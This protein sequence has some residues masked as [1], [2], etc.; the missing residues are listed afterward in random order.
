MA[1]SQAD[2]KQTMNVSIIKNILKSI[3]SRSKPAADELTTETIPGADRADWLLD[4]YSW[5]PDWKEILD[6]NWDDWNMLVKKTKDGPKVLI[7]TS[8]GG[9]SALTPFESLLGV[10]L[11]LRGADVHYILCDKSLPAC[12]NC[13]G[14]DIETQE[15]FVK[16]GPPICDWCFDVG[17][18]CLNQLGLQVHKFS[19]YLSNDDWL[20][21]EKIYEGLN[22]SN[23]L[24]YEDDG[25][26]L[27]EIVESAALRYF[28]RSDFAEQSLQK[29][30]LKRYFISTLLS[31][32]ALTRLFEK[33]QFDKA[34]SNQGIYVPQGNV[35]AVSRKFNCD[36]TVYDIAYR[37][38]CINIAHNDSHIRTF[39]DEPVEVWE[40]LPWNEAMES[41]IREYLESRWC[42]RLD[43]LSL[44]TEGADQEPIKLAK[45]I[46]LDL[47]KP[48]VGLLTNVIW[49]AQLAYP[50]VAFSNQ[51]EWIIHTIEYF[52]KRPDLQLL[53]RIHPA[54]IKSW[55]E[56]RQSVYDEIQKR[57]TK[58]PQ[59]V[60]VI[61]PDSKVN[62]Y[63]VM[64]NCDAVLIYGTTAGL[65]MACMGLP[66][67]IAG[68]AW[69]KNKG[70]GVDVSNPT[71]YESALNKLPFGKRLDQEQWQRAL[72]YAYHY[73][74]RLMIPIGVIDPVPYENA[75]Y[76]IKHLPL[77][78]FDR[79]ADVG[80]DIICDG[81]LNGSE[82][83]FPMENQ[84]LAP[85]VTN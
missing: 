68:Q 8:V 35:V 55:V 36:L 27:R 31:Q 1:L 62:T 21:A 50:G 78:G 83:I 22:D 64:M 58:I 23:L 5:I 2:S 29:P 16:N 79:G 32:W 75:P 71:E 40:N 43:W 17:E 7:A 57:F 56:S 77:T 14:S 38:L 80:L 28:G 26:K 34:V 42:G 24:D 45:E 10:A 65:E 72:K 18:R 37:K 54:E 12:Q 44:V 67:I 13:F 30:I 52:E 63:K 53:I 20:K 51:I 19:E 25:I 15:K 59:N 73:Y 41:R 11:T 61:K 47:K 60:F 81:I 3:L 46:G 4:G 39:T 70:I 48:V 84:D 33:H 6:S 74:L 69:I 76:V 66:V 49:D 9:N 82:Y 85:K